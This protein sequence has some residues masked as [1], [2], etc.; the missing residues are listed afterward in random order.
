MLSY[1]D[2]ILIISYFLFTLGI[3]IY[4]SKK[5]SE[6]I[7]SY[8]VSGRNLPWWLLGTSMVATTFAADTPLAVTGWIR[9]DGIWKNWFWWNYIFSHVFIILVFSRLWRRAEVITDNELIEIRYS[10][11]PAAFLRGFKAFYFSTIFNFIV[12]GW[13]ISAMVKV[14]KVFFGVDQI[15]AVV[16]CIIIALIYTS[17]SGLWGVV[18]TDFIQYFIAL[19]GTIVLVV[20]IINSNEIGGYSN[21][22]ENIQNLDYKTMSLFLSTPGAGEDFFSSSF[23]T[24]LIFVTVVWWSSHNADGGGYFIQRLSSAKNEKHALLGTAWFAFNHY[25]IRF[26]PWVL[27]AL[28]SIL[29]YPTAEITSGDNEAMYVAMINRFLGPGLKGL[30]LVSFFA[31]FMS[32][33]STH[34]NWGASYLLND[35]YKRFIKKNESEKHYVLVARI[36]TLILAV[37]AGLV[38]FQ[39]KNIGDAWIFLWAM[40][41]GIGIVLILRWFWWRINAWSEISALVSSLISIIIII[42]YTRINGIPLQLKHQILVVPVSIICWV[43]VTFLTKPEPI[44]KLMSFYRRV[45]PWGY[46]KPVTKNMDDLSYVEPIKPLLINWVF[47]S[48]FLILLMIGVGKFLLGYYLTGLLLLILSAVIF[49]VVYKRITKNL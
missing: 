23:F 9:T 19:V 24:F 11:K 5:A 33:I 42:L 45:R 26:W 47:G 27:V 36:L 40:S 22:V 3:G 6:N 14:F 4:Y 12:M 43:T 29:V 7:S 17:F 39:I 37:I 18:V 15:F 2:Y 20:I 31:A 28:A 34:L 1:I 10:S 41:S 44:N 49:F 25:V 8:F 32:T 46:W 13:V 48:S 30:L 16:F 21:F 38:A 35:I